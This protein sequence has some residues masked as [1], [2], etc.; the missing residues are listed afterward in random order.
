MPAPFC[1]AIKRAAS[2]FASAR[3][4]RRLHDFVFTD[5]Q[6]EEMML[7]I[8]LAFFLRNAEKRMT[9]MYPSPAGAIE[10][11]LGLH[12]WDERVEGHRFLVEMEP[13]VEALIVNRVGP[14]PLYYIAPIDECYRLT[15]VIR[16]KWRGLSGGTAVWAA[17]TEFFAELEKKASGVQ[18]RHA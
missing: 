5:L 14:E 6:W 16:T 7:P 18:V 13:E 17:I 2:F 3:R 11:Q 4:V 10:S 9:V 15:G 8:N 12:S 1:S